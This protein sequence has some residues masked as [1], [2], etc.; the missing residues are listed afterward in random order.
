MSRYDGHWLGQRDIARL[1]AY[2]H[3]T[4]RDVLTV[5]RAAK[6]D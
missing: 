6:A 5:V 4:G 3:D 1:T 2:A